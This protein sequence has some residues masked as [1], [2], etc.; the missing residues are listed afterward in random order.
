MALLAKLWVAG[1]NRSGPAENCVKTRH[2][3]HATVRQTT[4]TPNFGRDGAPIACDIRWLRPGSEEHRIPQPPSPPGFG[5]TG[6]IVLVRFN[7]P[8]FR[9]GSS[10][11]LFCWKIYWQDA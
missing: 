2:R 8:I 1:G 3:H 6:P 9:A 5:R 10:P 7:P 11:A 4:I